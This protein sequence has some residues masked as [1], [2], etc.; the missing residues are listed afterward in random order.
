MIGSPDQELLVAI[1][2]P[3]FDSSKADHSKNKES[4]KLSTKI[5]IALHCEEKIMERLLLG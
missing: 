1:L 3:K 4:Q 2:I 5:D